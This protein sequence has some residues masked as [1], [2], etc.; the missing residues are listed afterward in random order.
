MRF[1]LHGRLSLESVRDHV[2]VAKTARVNGEDVRLDWK[3]TCA[4]LHRP[5]LKLTDLTSPFRAVNSYVNTWQQIWRDTKAGSLRCCKMFHFTTSIRGAVLS[6]RIIVLTSRQIWNETFYSSST[7]LSSLQ[8]SLGSRCLLLENVNGF[9][10]K[11]AHLRA[12]QSAVYCAAFSMLV[13]AITTSLSPQGHVSYMSL[14]RIGR[15]R[16]LNRR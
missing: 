8:S 10:L 3:L 15:R 1:S 16:S 6:H 7:S 9:W 11:E 13:L 4:C 5:Q 14:K 2:T 12:F